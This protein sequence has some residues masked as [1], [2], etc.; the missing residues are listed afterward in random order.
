METTFEINTSV[1]VPEGSTLR[2][3]GAIL[4]NF[5]KRFLYIVKNKLY[6]VERVE[7]IEK[8]FIYPSLMH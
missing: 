6:S 3:I 4:Q 5:T 8:S 1:T 7:D 2:S